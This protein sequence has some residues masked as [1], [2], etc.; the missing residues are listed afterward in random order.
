MNLAVEQQSTV[1]VTVVMN[2]MAALK[3]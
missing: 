1:P 3:R 2:W